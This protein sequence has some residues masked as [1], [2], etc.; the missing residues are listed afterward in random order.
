MT[1][2]LNQSIPNGTTNTYQPIVTG[3]PYYIQGIE[4]TNSEYESGYQAT[5]WYQPTATIKLYVN[6]EIVYR[7]TTKSTIK[8]TTFFL[9]H[10]IHNIQQASK[11]INQPKQINH[12]TIKLVTINHQR[13]L[14][15]KPPP[16]ISRR[17]KI[18]PLF[19]N[20][21]TQPI[22]T[23]QRLQSSHMITKVLKQPIPLIILF[24]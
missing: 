17:S 18:Q 3:K 21:Q 4:S 19:P 12:T 20:H 5:N 9:N 7:G 1:I 11:L 6:Q 8:K 13:T 24:K 22:H 10:Q 14:V 2:L 16:F 15:L 23:N